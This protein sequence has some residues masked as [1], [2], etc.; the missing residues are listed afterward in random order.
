MWQDGGQKPAD[1]DSSILEQKLLDNANDV[2]FKAHSQTYSLSF[3]GKCPKIWHLPLIDHWGTM[4]K[5]SS[6][7][8]RYDT[9]KHYLWNQE[10]CEK[11][12]PVCLCSRC[13][14][15]QIE[16]GVTKVSWH[17]GVFMA[18]PWNHYMCVLITVSLEE[19]W[20]LLL[21]LTTGTRT[22]S[23]KQDTRYN[24]CVISK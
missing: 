5:G 7:P 2:K 23:L 4:T 22:S 17:G 6:P 24:A 10:G 1:V 14:V 13:H 12:A 20:V 8:P 3:R 15:W 18:T 19:K 9:D 11:T 21:Y 16:V